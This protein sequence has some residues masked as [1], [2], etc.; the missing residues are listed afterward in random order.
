MEY[1]LRIRYSL[2]S[3]HETVAWKA[4]CTKRLWAVNANWNADNDGWNANANS[5]DN[6]NR[7]NAGN[8]V[9]SRNFLVFSPD[10]MSWRVFI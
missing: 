6:P 4:L 10:V 3:N 2:K 7:W 1:R 8:Q 5:V 9:V